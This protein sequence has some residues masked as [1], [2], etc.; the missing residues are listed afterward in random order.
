[1][2]DSVGGC[3][4]QELY[5][6]VEVV[7][8]LPVPQSTGI[9]APNPALQPL[10]DLV[11]YQ[12]VSIPAYMHLELLGSKSCDVGLLL[13]MFLDSNVTLTLFCFSQG[14][15]CSRASTFIVWLA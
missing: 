12:G 14:P 6:L 13:L 8:R 5:H 3:E 1:M 10:H 9:Y 4:D 15:G 2:G 7:C 11:I